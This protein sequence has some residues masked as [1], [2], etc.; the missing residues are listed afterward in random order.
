M[1]KELRQLFSRAST[2]LLLF[3]C[4]STRT[5]VSLPI[6]ARLDAAFLPGSR[7]VRSVVE[8]RSV[9][10]LPQA[11]RLVAIP[12]S[13]QSGGTVLSGNRRRSRCRGCR[14]R[15]VA[16]PPPSAR[17]SVLTA[18][19]DEEDRRGRMTG[20]GIRPT[21]Q[22]LASGVRAFARRASRASS[23]RSRHFSRVGANRRPRRRNGAPGLA[24]PP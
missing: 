19:M 13:G 10:S 16:S 3:R 2:E 21:R 24:K 9:G 15:V 5:A 23:P 20:S 17:P 8:G 12:N 7:S 1:T 11:Q 6:S 4:L 14:C 22:R 18:R